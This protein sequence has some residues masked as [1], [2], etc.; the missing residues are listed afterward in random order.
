MSTALAP[1]Q[2]NVTQQNRPSCNGP[3]HIYGR[4][5]LPAAWGVQLLMSTGG[6]RRELAAPF[7]TDQEP[8]A[9]SC[10]LI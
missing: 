8:G 2:L 9:A 3:H 10:R 7:C 4:R 5:C 1:I 6:Q